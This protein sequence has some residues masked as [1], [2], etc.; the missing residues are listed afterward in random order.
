MEESPAVIDQ[1]P[2]DGRLRLAFLSAVVS[3]AAAFAASSAPIPLFNLYRAEEGFSNADISLTVVAYDLP[4]LAALLVMGRLSNHV[5]RRP[6]A[7]AS[8]GLLALGCLV[9]L[10]V[11]HIGVLIAGRLLMGFGAGLAS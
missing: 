7:I 9:L 8:L 11:H 3:L 5:G 10:H 2:R 4:T 6:T 1:V